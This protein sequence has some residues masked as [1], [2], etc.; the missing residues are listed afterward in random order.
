MRLRA[1]LFATVALAGSGAL[2]WHLA[3]AATDYVERGTERQVRTALE[4]AGQDWAAVTTDGLIVRLDGM[5]PDETSR[6]R[7]TEIV[8]RVIDPARLDDRTQVARADPLAPPPFALELLR[9]ED[10]VSLIGL[11]PQG[12]G[13]EEIRDALA[14]GGVAADVT[15]MLETAKHPAP[16]DWRPSLEFAL[17]VLAD[18]P[19]AKIS[20][21]P[22]RVE[23]IAVAES[24]AARDTLAAR[25]RAAAPD[26]MDLTLEISAP[27]PVIA[28][29][30]IAYA[31]QDGQ[32][33]FEACSAPDTG[34]LAE[35]LTVARATG[36]Q[37]EPDCAIGLGAPTPDWAAAVTA[38]LAALRDLD[39]GRFEISGTSAVLTGPDAADHATLNA[40]GAQLEAA[41]PD[42]IS[43]RTVAPPRMQAGADGADVYAPRF[44]ATLAADGAVR[45]AGAVQ[46][47]ASQAAVRSYAASVF[48]HD[49][50]V[51]ETVIDPNLPDGW[52][53]RVLA[54]IDALAVTTEGRLTVG[55]AEVELDG[56]GISAGADMTAEQL[57]RTRAGPAEVDIRFDEAAARA[58][59]LAARPAREICADDIAAILDAGSIVFRAG[60]AEIDPASRGVIAAIADVLRSC[61]GAAFEVAG[62][63]DSQGDPDDNQE[64]SEARA[65]AVRDALEAEDLPLIELGARGYGAERPVAENET[66][67]GRRANRRIELTLAEPG[68]LS[69]AEVDRGPDPE[70]C[71]GEVADILGDGSSLRFAMG[72]SDFDPESVGLIAEIAEAMQAC[73]GSAFRIGGHTDSQGPS[74]VN[75]R[76]SEERAQAVMA[77]L[78]DE[79]LAEV[80][81]SARGHG[82][83]LPVA[84]NDTPD[85]RARNRRIEIS[86]V[87][88]ATGAPDEGRRGPQ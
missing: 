31:L 16:P 14:A 84:D 63:T 51:D 46:D 50:V 86:L 39:G 70:E 12:D 67:E 26:G 3:G 10:E 66:A 6:F 11:V 19:R 9:N 42:V 33:R 40:A 2:A 17:S 45:L 30:A 74:E 32:G 79:G 36:L 15:D 58:A 22:G 48:G 64:L 44:E 4:A 81:L 83:D 61:P 62:H 21:Q 82:E 38:G 69:E 80:T 49:R 29:F 87:V 55:A 88:P 75:L 37:D 13:W 78:V 76:L 59:E 57:L 25:L 47:R 52:P 8:R 34:A 53:G 85:G 73:P 5:A 65:R 18:L 60:S 27:R 72:S 24:A 56:W 35:I 7:A 43:L 54:G 77:A 28:P 41:L 20:V 23:V 71:A 68:A 1:L